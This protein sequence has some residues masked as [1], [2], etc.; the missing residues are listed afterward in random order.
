[1]NIQQSFGLLIL[2]LLLLSFVSELLLAPLLSTSSAWRLGQDLIL[3][4]VIIIATYR[5]FLKPLQQLAIDLQNNLPSPFKQLKHSD[6]LSQSLDT[7]I[8]QMIERNEKAFDDLADSVARLSPMSEEL[9]ITY[10][11]ITQNANQQNSHSRI[12]E[13][14]ISQIKQAT[15]SLSSQV[16]EMS[17][18]TTDGN[19]ATS[20]AEQAMMQTVESLNSLTDDIANASSEMTILKEGSDNIHSILEVIQS[21]AE[22]T[23]LLALNAAIEAARAGEHGRGFAVVADEVRTLAEQ[24]RSS[25]SEVGQMIQALQSGTNRVVDAMNVSIKKTEETVKKTDYSREQLELIHGIIGRIDVV[26]HDVSQAM[27]HQVKADAEAEHSVVS[28][29]KLNELALENTHV[30]AV[31]ADDVLALHGVLVDKFEQHGFEKDHWPTHRR[32]QIRPD[33]EIK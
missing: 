26:S 15:Q 19:N 29:A 11:S 8:N 31:T 25:A 27:I 9:R 17:K 12:L 16:D 18:I 28:M 21:I 5:L 23:N 2:S 3:L 33:A 10:D 14:S 13:Q 7:P 30:Q 20:T 24:T 4:T 6:S 32:N 22:Q 1:M